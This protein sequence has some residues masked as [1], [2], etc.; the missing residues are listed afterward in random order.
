MKIVYGPIR[1]LGFGK[2]MVVDPIC[3]HPK[4]CNFNCVYCRLGQRGILILERTKFLDERSIIEQAGECLFRDECDM[5][6]FKGTGEPLLASNIFSMVRKLKETAP[7]KVALLTNCSLLRDPEVLSGLGAFDIIVAKLDAADEDTFQRVNRPHPSIKFSE[8]LEG[9]K[10]ARRLFE[11]SFRV[12]VTLVRENLNGL[13]GIAQICRDI[14]VDLVYLN[15]PEN[16]DPPHQVTK[17][18]MQSA[19][20][21]FVGVHCACAQDKK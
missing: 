17:R 19:L 20:D 9:L 14:C 2:A 10:E 18:E 11:G 6:M 7:K 15:T 21:K 3:R 16:C 4:V 13:E 1:S 12:Q 8:M 5:I